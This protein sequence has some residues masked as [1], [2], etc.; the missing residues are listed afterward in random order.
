MKKHPE[1]NTEPLDIEDLVKIGQVQGP[2]PYFL[3]RDMTGSAELV[4][5][6]YQYLIDA[7]TRLGLDN[8]TWED[9][10]LIFDEAHNLE[11]GLGA[12]VRQLGSI[13][14]QKFICKPCQYLPAGERC[15]GLSSHGSMPKSCMMRPTTWKWACS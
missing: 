6:P 10:I 8:I 4:F 11:V 3:S 7:K 9:A 2:C 1:A 13:S 15:S 12:G 5:M 14:Q